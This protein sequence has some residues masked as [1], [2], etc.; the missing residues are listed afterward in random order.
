M[1]WSA[2]ETRDSLPSGGVGSCAGAREDEK[3]ARRRLVATQ[4][5]TYNREDVTQAPPPIKASRLI[6]SMAATKTIAKGQHDWLIG[7]HDIR[8]ACFHA[9]GSGKVVII[10][11]RGLAPPGVGWGALKALHGARESSKRWGN[12]VT[13]T[14]KLE[15]ARQVVLV[16]MMFGSDSFGYA[17]C[18]HGDDFLT[19]GTASVGAHDEIDRVLTNNFDAKMAIRWTLEGFEWGANPK[20]V[21]DLLV[22]AGFNEDSKGAPS[23][24]STAAGRRDGGDDL[25]GEAATDFKQDAGAALYLSIDRPTVQFVA[26]QV[27][28]GMSM[29]TSRG[30]Q[31][32]RVARYALKYPTEVRLFKCQKEPGG[33]C[34]YTDTDWAADELTR[35]ST[36]CKVE[37]Y[38]DHMLDCSVAKQATIASSSGVAEFYGIARAVAIGKQTSQI[39]RQMGLASD[40]ATASGSSAARGIGAWTGS[41][42]DRHLA[43]KELC[44]QEALRNKEFELAIAHAAEGQHLARAI[45]WTPEGFEW[46]ANPKQVEDLLLALAG[47]NK[48]SKGAPTPSSISTAAGRRDRDD[49]L[50]GEA[51]T[52]F[53][54]DAGTALYLSIDRPTVQFAASQVMARI[55][56][57]K[58][59]HGLQLQRV[60]LFKCQ[61]EPGGLCVYTETDWAADELTRK[62]TSCKVERYGDH[63]LDCSVAKQATIASPSGEAEFYGIARAVAIGKQT[64]QTLRQM[65]LA[66][67]LA[68]ASGSSAARGIG[69]WTGSGADRHLAI[70]ELW[71]QEALRNKEFELAI[72]DALLNWG[73]HRHEGACSR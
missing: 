27:M 50:E 31:L 43:I 65:G 16:P 37:R 24:K 52:N 42:A 19:A 29:P 25:E 54:Q 60:W 7:R 35:K 36:S 17:T 33:L 21:D 3:A 64:S 71:L 38:G 23:S 72:V 40:L 68:A 10:P 9:A 6:V 12:E 26:S 61:K 62:S 41:G 56:M 51:A 53:K 28:A 66:S 44:V 70:K 49:D 73:R 57:P 18:C 14:M 13:D 30:L 15:G 47:F 11:H 55:G 34:V 8:A 22:L 1:A 32:Q 67:D 45:R 48:D 69:A 58:V 63:M 2:A 20:H 5:N 46:G 59:L 4:V 39:L